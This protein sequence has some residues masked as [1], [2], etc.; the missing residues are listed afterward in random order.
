MTNSRAKGWRMYLSLALGAIVAVATFRS[1]A[2]IPSPEK[3]LPDDTLLL[4]TAPDFS[5]LREIYK[6]SAQSQLWNDPTMRPF[7]EK[8]LSKWND[9][10]VK[11]LENELKIHFDDYLSLPQGQV[12]FAVTLSGP[13][14]KENES[15]GLLLLVDTRDKSNQLK[16]NLADLRKKWVEA[17]KQ[18]KTEKIRD[19]EFSVLTVTSND[20][21]R[22]LRKLFPPRPEVQELGAENEPKKASSRHEWVIGQA[23][24]LL[25]IGNSMRVIE[26]VVA[27]LKGGQQPSL[28]EAAAYDANHQA[29]FKSSP[30]YGWVNVKAFVELI[31]REASQKK[32]S[33]APDPFGNISP[34]K[35]LTATGL[36]SVKTIAFN[37]QHSPGGLLFE[38]YLTVPESGRQ[39]FFKI[40]AG[41]SKDPK[42]PPFVPADA[43]KFQ[44][45]RV[46]GKKAWAALEKMLSDVS[47]QAGSSLKFLLEAANSAAKERDPGFDVKSS[48]IGNLGDDLITYQKRPRGTTP[49]DLRSP[50]SLYLLGSPN[51]E[52]LAAAFKSVLGFLSQQSAKT[53]EREFLGRKIFSLPAPAL[54]LPVPTAATPAPPRT[55]SFAASGGYVAFSTDVSML[56]EY[57]RSGDSQGKALRETAGLTEAAQKVIGPGAVMF[58]YQN[59]VEAM[60][61]AFELLKNDPASATNAFPFAALSGALPLPNPTAALRDWSDFTL[62][63]SFD[64]IAKYFCF[65]VYGGSATSQGLSFKLFAPAPPQL[66]SNQGSGSER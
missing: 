41:E 28:G 42:P 63:P 1:H 7:K 43:V 46:D 33:D 4:V 50:P 32:P 44:R 49:A 8:F 58:G 25:I 27:L 12:S 52:H 2:A 66:K 29:L 51:P 54:P 40:L 65:T 39:G 17:E 15:P 31:T 3:L 60:R 30:F 5:K 23:E 26:K 56:E 59:Q 20:T 37:F 10:F 13:D 9:E 34:E 21:P 47:P 64:K 53:N 24:S 45:W 55:L 38:L 61:V 19:Y 16:A 35:V 6:A 57:L 62:L 36:A 14:D 18:V 48:L 22:T 11:P